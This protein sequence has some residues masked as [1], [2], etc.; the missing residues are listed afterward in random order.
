MADMEAEEQEG[1]Q[2]PQQPT[3]F[4]S[5]EDQARQ[6][7]GQSYDEGVM[8]IN[9][10][11]REVVIDAKGERFK[12][13]CSLEQ[14]KEKWLKERTVIV[15]FH[16]NSRNLTR[17]V[18]EDLIR[19]YEDG[20]M[21]RRLFSPEVRRGRITFEG[22]NIIS[23]VAKSP[24]VAAWMVQ[25]ASTNL[26]LRGVDYPVMFKSW[27]TKADLKELR[28]KEAETNFWIVALR[29]PLE[30]FYYLPS[31]VEGLIGGVK[32]MH[33]PEADRSRTKLMNV[34]FDMDPQAR[35]NVVTAGTLSLIGVQW[36]KLDAVREQNV[37]EL[38]MIALAPGV[39]V[40]I[41]LHVNEK[42]ADSEN[43]HSPF[44]RDSLIAPWRSS[45]RLMDSPQTDLTQDSEM[46]QQTEVELTV[47]ERLS[48]DR[49]VTLEELAQTLKVMAAGKSPGR[50]GLTVEFFHCCWE[51]LGP[52]LVE[53]YNRV[54]VGERLGEGMTLGIISLMLK[55]GDK[56]NVRNYR[57]ISLLNVDYKIL[58]K[59]MAIRLRRILPRLVERDQGAFVQ[60]RSIFLNILTAIESVEVMQMENRDM[61]I[62]LLDLEK[63]YDRVGWSF[64]LTTLRKMGFGEGF[65]RWLEVP[66]NCIRKHQVIKGLPLGAGRE[67]R[68]KALADDLFLISEN[69]VFSLAAV[70]AVLQEYSLVSE[71]QVNWNKSA[72]ILPKDFSRVVEWGMHRVDSTEG[73]RFLG[74]LISLEVMSTAQGAVIQH[75]IAAK[76]KGWG[77]A[78][79]LSL[80][81]RAL[82]IN[83]ALFSLFW[84]VA[85]VREIPRPVILEIKRLASRFLWKPRAGQEEGFLVKVAWDLITQ[86]SSAPG[87]FGKAWVQRGVSMV[88]D[89]L[90][91][92]LGTWNQGREVYEKLQGLRNVEQHLQEIRQAIPLPWKNMLGPEGRDPTDTWYVPTVPTVPPTVWKLQD[93]T[94]S[95][96]RKVTEWFVSV[97]DGSLREGQ[98]RTIQIW[99]NPPQIR[100][101]QRRDGRGM[102][103]QT[104]WVG[105]TPLRELRIDPEAWSRSGGKITRAHPQAV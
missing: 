39:T 54:L 7:I 14:I 40:R 60:G 67:C 9:P 92:L 42:L 80:F 30:P 6:S 90:D 76:L 55:K 98:E 78:W 43:L 47:Q 50:N 77:S 1:G 59:T 70:K 35:I 68:A 79:H 64:A 17:G 91:P 29:V 95:G 87:A 10:N 72:Y 44:V 89:L 99:D 31:T 57:P 102:V 74:V 94:E 48:L 63:A 11:F 2:H 88:G 100:V 5:I 104:Q 82:V 73:E 28:L 81:G 105:Q 46:W 41:P 45:T 83:S 38:E 62:L 49:L 85:R 15:V 34:K 66:L 69:S 58:A 12:V 25:K 51:S 71:A 18:K 23:Y 32:N 4:W 103:T 26:N 97:T 86:T 24:K 16:D 56:V 27:T 13:N 101:I 20:W 37:Q 61:T 3:I 53:I 8:Q 52:P 36:F 96:F 93:V 84:F 19:A 21:A 65:C 22:A 75:R 33:P